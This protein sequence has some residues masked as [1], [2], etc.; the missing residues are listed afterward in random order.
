MKASDTILCSESYKAELVKD[1]EIE[2]I[3]FVKRFT[4]IA[5]KAIGS[6]QNTDLDMIYLPLF[7][8]WH[9]CLYTLCE[10]LRDS[11]YEMDASLYSA[12]NK[13]SYKNK[14][15]NIPRTNFSNKSS[16]GDV[17]DDDDDD[18]DNVIDENQVHADEYRQMKMESRRGTTYD[19]NNGPAIPDL[20]GYDKSNSATSLVKSRA[21]SLGLW[22]GRAEGTYAA[23]DLING[24]VLNLS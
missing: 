7:R 23:V 17:D 22:L 3:L 20:Q 4:G 6:I 24:S 14:N 5:L 2:D 13:E 15:Y 19:A 8:H 11:S 10:W 18:N 21:S 16:G 1:N 12:S 9:V